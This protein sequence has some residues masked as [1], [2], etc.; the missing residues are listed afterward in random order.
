MAVEKDMCTEEYITIDK[1]ASRLELKPKT[2][3]NKMALG[4]FKK[5]V[6]YF[7]RKGLGTR[8]K[9]SAVVT[10]LEGTEEQLTQD[11]N[12]SIPMAKGYSLGHPLDCDR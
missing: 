6:H 7:R 4:I 9:W 2:I 12:K 10:W 11:D 8:F 3:S 5:G 1:V